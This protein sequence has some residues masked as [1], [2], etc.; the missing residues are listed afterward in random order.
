[1]YHRAL[2]WKEYLQA[3]GYRQ[4]I[5]KLI[6]SSDPDVLQT[7]FPLKAFI[8][9]A[10]T[11]KGAGYIAPPT[12]LQQ[13]LVSY[14]SP[15]PEE[16]FPA[17]AW[18]EEHVAWA[19]EQD[20]PTISALMRETWGQTESTVTA[21]KRRDAN[22]AFQEGSAAYQAGDFDAGSRWFTNAVSRYHDILTHN[23][24]DF[25][26]HL[27][28]GMIHMYRFHPEPD[29]GLALE[30]FSEAA[31][32]TSRRVDANRHKL[33]PYAAQAFRLAAFAAYQLGRDP[34]AVTHMRSAC[35]Q[36]P[37]SGQN[38]FDYAKFSAVAQL[39]DMIIPNLQNALEQ[40][41]MYAL[42]TL[43]DA[44]FQPYQDELAVMLRQ[45]S[46]LSHIEAQETWSELQAELHRYPIAS[47]EEA[48]FVPLQQAI[49]GFIAEN[50]LFSHKKAINTAEELRQ[51]LIELRLPEREALK[52]QADALLRMVEEKA[53]AWVFPPALDVELQTA[54]QTTKTQ[55]TS[56]D[57]YSTT[58]QVKNAAEY[59]AHLF[60]AAT[61]DKSLT[62]HTSAVQLVR[63][64]P[65]SKTLV[66][67]GWE[68]R[69]RIWDVVT[70]GERALLMGQTG[71]VQAVQYSPS[72]DVIAI[73]MYERVRLLDPVDG[74]QVGALQKHDGNI[75]SL[76]FHPTRDIIAAGLNDRTVRI[77]NLV[78]GHM[79]DIL[80]GHDDWV[81][82]VQFSPNGELLA[83]A[84]RD[85]TVQIYETTAF[86]EIHTL[87]GHESSVMDVDFSPDGTLLATASA[88]QTV[89]LWK[90]ETGEQIAKLD[91][92][93]DV[94][95]KV[96]FTP[97]G[98]SLM[99]ASHDYT[100]I[101]WRLREGY[102]K[103]TLKGHTAEIL[104]I[105]I[106][107]DGT[108]AATASADESIRLWQV[109][110]GH[111]RKML[112]GH[113]G[114]VYSVDF[115]TNGAMLASSGG[116]SQVKL[117]GLALTQEEWERTL[118]NW[119]SAEAAERERRQARRQARREAARQRKIWRSE[120]KCEICG[121][122]LGLFEKSL[123][124]HR[125]S[126]HRNSEA[127][128]TT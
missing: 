110:N 113:M 7:D 93:K 10:L 66:T 79:V 45:R 115:S 80:E 36:A 18:I 19:W 108:I 5:L 64:S 56:A 20:S 23:D 31:R 123:H 1:M 25:A 97:D 65:D 70:G 2:N 109:E 105:A 47:E 104:D 84:S 68:H 69:A 30:H 78:Y 53:K 52:R 88:D 87:K 16:S 6:Q 91:A 89:Q 124:P 107:P 86:K 71:D 76:S 48:Q 4:H 118:A 39:G 90:L 59:C 67:C 81:M 114:Q 22:L 82:K 29:W 106:S 60:E 46:E 57:T 116:D 26:A 122:K 103:I 55:L 3:H 61:Q 14:L 13:T 85:N 73:E 100:A 102:P 41:Q 8:F 101:I 62:G 28:A 34:I 40:D 127:G 128:E 98:K 54:L 63:F 92:H 11:S 33:A 24:M 120:G 32:L 94:V 44:D 51:R 75:R 38:W 119:T 74:R 96:K 83:T 50:T 15:S 35:E 43:L 49:T 21:R 9:Q 77:W 27:S 72:A 58:L 111:L 117:W 42:L 112:D 12:L 37:E 99:T 95:N 121:K 126:Q 17:F 125:C